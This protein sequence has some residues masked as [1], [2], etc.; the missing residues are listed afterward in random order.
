MQRA[1]DLRRKKKNLPYAGLRKL[2]V[3]FPKDTIDCYVPVYAL[4][5]CCEMLEKRF[6]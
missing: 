3:W 5:N 1:F 4:V 2:G 6:S